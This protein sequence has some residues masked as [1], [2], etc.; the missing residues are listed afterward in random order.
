M[1][2]EYPT[3]GT[4]FNK[5]ILRKSTEILTLNKELQKLI[6]LSVKDNRNDARVKLTWNL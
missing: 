3:S 5:D 4:Y 1:K 2:V 6:K